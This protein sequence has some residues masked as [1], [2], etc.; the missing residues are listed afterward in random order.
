MTTC[1]DASCNFGRAVAAAAPFVEAD[2]DGS[3]LGRAI[4]DISELEALG[5]EDEED[6]VL[7]LVGMVL[8]PVEEGRFDVMVVEYVD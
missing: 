6:G 3:K 4:F 8:R 7:D 2:V 1:F 5:I